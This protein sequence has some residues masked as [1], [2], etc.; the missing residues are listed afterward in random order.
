MLAFPSTMNFYYAKSMSTTTLHSCVRWCCGNCVMPIHVKSLTNK[1]CTTI[2]T[3]EVVYKGYPTNSRHSFMIQ[4]ANNGN[5]VAWP[6]VA[7]VESKTETSTS[8]NWHYCGFLI[9]GKR[10]L[11]QVVSYPELNHFWSRAL[12]ARPVKVH[13]CFST[14]SFD[15]L[16]PCDGVS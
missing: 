10:K 2:I 4:I 12:R 11:R 1:T 7:E 14:K 5:R 16:S 9:C 8:Y 3:V 13:R 6:I 15:I